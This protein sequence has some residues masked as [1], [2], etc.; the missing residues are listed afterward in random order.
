MIDLKQLWIDMDNDNQAAV[1]SGIKAGELG[2]GEK[3]KKSSGQ[4]KREDVKDRKLKRDNTKTDG[5]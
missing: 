4:K 1:L 2:F 3:P 5:S